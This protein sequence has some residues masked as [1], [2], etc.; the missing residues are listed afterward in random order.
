MPVRKKGKRRGEGPRFTLLLVPGSQGRV[1]GVD[2]PYRVARALLVVTGLLAGVGGFLFLRAFETSG[3][4]SE[5][6][7]LR[8]TRRVQEEELRKIQTKARQVEERLQSL[9][10]LERQ[11][12]GLMGQGGDTRP[13]ESTETAVGP[14]GGRSIP[15]SE[16]PDTEHLAR[17]LDRHHA[18]LSRVEQRLRSGLESL[19]SVPTSFPARARITS[20]FGARR[21]PF[22][23]RMEFHD[24]IDLDLP[25]GAPVRAAAAGRVVSA[26]RE[27]AYG[28]TV[29]LAHGHG[30]VSRYA[31]LST[32]GV[33]AGDRVE[34]GDIIGRVGSTGRSTGAH[35][36]YTVLREGRL[37][38]PLELLLQD[39]NA[40][41]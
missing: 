25:Y 41:R 16:R 31:H 6:H 9:D 24:G 17:S 36:H 40:A 22:G 38:D 11:I 28:N 34:R 32:L 29:T 18:D 35:L 13:L 4:R 21:S 7:R 1:L 23:R 8:H 27:P 10:V 26:E 2:L 19:L 30:W 12:R 3:E 37:L 33:A 20:R 14:Q 5:L 39:T 15:L